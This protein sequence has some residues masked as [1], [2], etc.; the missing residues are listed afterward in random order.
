MLSLPADTPQTVV[1]PVWVI[2]VGVMMPWIASGVAVFIALRKAP[3]EVKKIKKDIDLE[4][5]DMAERLQRLASKTREDYTKAL[6][7]NQTLRQEFADYKKATDAS[8]ASIV[9]AHQKEVQEL[10]AELTEARQ[11][12]TKAWNYAK[13]L[14]GQLH[15]IDPDIEPVPLE[16]IKKPAVKP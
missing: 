15:S 4:D 2:W 9:A 7:D 8:I 14:V 11:E 13:R 10:R 16:P 12:A 5:V 3:F 1:L 6:E